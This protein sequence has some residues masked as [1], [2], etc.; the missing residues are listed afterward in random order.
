LGGGANSRLSPLGGGG[1]NRGGS[2]WKPYSWG[3]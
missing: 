2:N 1:G 3:G